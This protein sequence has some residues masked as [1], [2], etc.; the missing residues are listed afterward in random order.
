MMDSPVMVGGPVPP[1]EL[2]LPKRYAHVL[3]SRTYLEKGAF[4]D[5]NKNLRSDHPEL[6]VWVPNVMTSV[7]M[8]DRRGESPHTEGKPCED[9]GR[10][11][12]R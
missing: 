12:Q 9:G 11:L 3:T 8:G 6:Q 10:I 7:L 4:A 5:I 2:L 1:V